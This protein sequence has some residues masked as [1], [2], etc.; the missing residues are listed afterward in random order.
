MRPSAL[1]LFLRRSFPTR[2]CT[3]RNVGRNG[4]WK[5]GA[6]EKKQHLLTRLLARTHGRSFLLAAILCLPVDPT[7]Y[8]GKVLP[9][10]R[11]PRLF[12]SAITLFSFTEHSSA[13]RG[14]AKAGNSFDKTKFLRCI[15]ASKRSNLPRVRTISF[16]PDIPFRSSSSTVFIET[17]L[18]VLFA[19]MCRDIPILKADDFI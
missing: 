3:R 1:S 16:I 19:S 12:L 4:G 9:V 8:P 6:K 13:G 5:R 14:Y 7:F 15:V 18:L 10:I 17:F 11:F 2:T